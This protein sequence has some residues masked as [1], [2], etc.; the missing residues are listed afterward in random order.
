MKII[1]TE[2]QYKQILFEDRIGRS[3]VRQ[4]VRDLTTI[5]KRNEEGEF[6]LPS[7]VLPDGEEMDFYQ[8]DDYEVEFAV[9]FKIIYDDSINRFLINGS[10]SIED[11]T[12]EIILKVNPDNLKKQ[13]YDII[14]ELNILVAHELEHGLQGYY[15]EFDLDVEE[16]KK[17]KKYYVQPH[18]IPA[19]IQG[20]RRLAKLKNIPFEDV[21]RDWF[22]NNK[23]FHQLK[24]KQLEKVIQKLLDFNKDKYGK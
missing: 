6:Y 24:P 20:F 22:D 11:D 10:Y 18:E 21:V 16:P 12:I 17:S 9:E 7:D 15:D 14:G 13:M 3:V 23:T 5:I 4:V 1:I 2:N 8:F 19:Q